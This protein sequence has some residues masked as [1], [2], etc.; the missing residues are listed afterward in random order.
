MKLFDTR[1]PGLARAW[2]SNGLPTMSASQQWRSS[3][4]ALLGIGLCGLLLHAMP[5]HSH[6]LIAPVGA[7][8]VILFVQPHSPVALP[9][10]VISSY[11]F[12]TLVGLVSV[13]GV[14]DNVLAAAIG[15]AVTV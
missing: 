10:S 9:R 7:S 8:V 15:V 3:L 1:F 2:M 13:S 11:F 4:G 6:W 5:L 12:A 14:P